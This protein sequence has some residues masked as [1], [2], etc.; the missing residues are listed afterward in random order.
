MNMQQ[1]MAQAQRMQRDLETKKKEISKMTFVG[2]SDWFE[3]SCN[4]DK[5]IKSVKILS[6]DVFDKENADILSDMLVIAINNCLKQV[7]KETESKL[8]NLGGLS[9]LF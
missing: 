2:K 6:E 9:G 3:I 4:G 7:D 1:I 5:E 8:G